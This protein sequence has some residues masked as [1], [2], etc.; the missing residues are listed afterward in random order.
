MPVNRWPAD[1][2]PG[3][4]V[5]QIKIDREI[6]AIQRHDAADDNVILTGVLPIA[7]DDCVRLRRRC[8]HVGPRQGAE[9]T[10]ALQ[11]VFYDRATSKPPSPAAAFANGTMA[12]GTGSATPLVTSILSCAQ[13]GDGA[14]GSQQ[15]GREIAGE[16]AFV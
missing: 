1:P 9:T 14:A 7:H 5:E 4:Y 12:T 13:A 16:T 15:G 6:A 10:T 11:V 2:L 8:R 3:Q